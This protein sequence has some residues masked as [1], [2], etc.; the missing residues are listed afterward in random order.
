M[1]EWAPNIAWVSTIWT[2]S[3][4][5]SLATFFILFLFQRNA[6]CGVQGTRYE[7]RGEKKITV[8]QFGDSCAT[9]YSK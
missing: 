5:K 9:K 6:E 2:V 3:N 7:S 8:D 1:P 4:P